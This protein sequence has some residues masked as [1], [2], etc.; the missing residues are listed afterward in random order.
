MKVNVE[1]ARKIIKVFNAKF[2]QLTVMEIYDSSDGIIVKAVRYP[3]KTELG[4]PYYQYFPENNLVITANPFD[5]SDW[6]KGIANDKN[7]IYRNSE[8]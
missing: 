1:K 6:F 3:G 2:P 8:Y 7:M 5:K 4:I